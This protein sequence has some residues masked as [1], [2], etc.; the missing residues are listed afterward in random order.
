V[1]SDRRGGSGDWAESGNGAAMKL[2]G[3]KGKRIARVTLEPRGR[4]Y[5]FR[6]HSGRIMFTVMCDGL[7]DKYGNFFDESSQ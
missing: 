1:P 5:E 2:N 7:F 3:L 4:W 6:D